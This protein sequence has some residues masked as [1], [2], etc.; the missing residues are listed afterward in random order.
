MNDL[1]SKRVLID[2]ILTFLS[3][4]GIEV[5]VEAIGEPTF[6]PG[7]KV[8]EGTLI[9]DDTELEY[10][11]DLLHEAGHLAIVTEEKRL[12][13]EVGQK[14]KE[15]MMAIAWSYAAAHQLG[16][17]ASVVIHPGGYHGWRESFIESLNQGTFPGVSLLQ[18]IGLTIERDQAVKLGR[19]GYPSMIRWLL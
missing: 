2:K 14:A 9:V 3:E 7:I 11:G 8:G 12:S 13:G 6:L 17:D 10:P 18:E 1:E 5:R 19:A 15:E 4:I 16:L